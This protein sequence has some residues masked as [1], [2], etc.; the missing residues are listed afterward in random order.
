MKFIIFWEFN[1]TFI[2]RE[3]LASEFNLREDH[4]SR[5]KPIAPP[6]WAAENK[7]QRTNIGS[8][9]RIAGDPVAINLQSGGTPT[10]H[11]FARNGEGVTKCLAGAT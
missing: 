3:L 9:Y 5:I 7:T 10:Q 11:V 2:N 4:G 1:G 6:G 8:A